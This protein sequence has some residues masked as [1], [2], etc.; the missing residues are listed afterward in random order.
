MDAP[1]SSQKSECDYPKVNYSK[2]INRPAMFE[3]LTKDLKRYTAKSPKLTRE[4][5]QSHFQN[6]SENAV[7]KPSSCI[8]LSRVAVVIPFRGDGIMSQ[9]RELQLTMMLYYLPQFMIEQ[10][11][12]FKIFVVEQTWSETFSRA[13]LLN[14]AQCARI[15]IP[16]AERKK[17]FEIFKK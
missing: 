15:T 1:T 9:G 4:S 10:N 13:T 6:S 2:T 3:E 8:S 17:F 16:P 11:I 14:V 7:F 12:E 5:V